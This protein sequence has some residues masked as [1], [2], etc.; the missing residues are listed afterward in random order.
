ME[1]H[2]A[3]TAVDGRASLGAEG[4]DGAVGFRAQLDLSIRLGARA[5][6]DLA[7]NRARRGT[8]HDHAGA[9]FGIVAAAGFPV[10]NGRARRGARRIFREQSAKH[11][12]RHSERDPAGHQD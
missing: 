12:Y 2:D 9:P 11:P 5:H 7:P 6:E 1:A 10:A 4:D 3:L 8:Q